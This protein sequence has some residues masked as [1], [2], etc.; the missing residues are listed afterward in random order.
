MMSRLEIALVVRP[1][2]GGSRRLTWMDLYRQP[3]VIRKRT[4]KSH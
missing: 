3:Y 2:D 1:E 4:G